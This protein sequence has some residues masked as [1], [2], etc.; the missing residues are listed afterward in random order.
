MNPFP[1]LVGTTRVKVGDVLQMNSLGLD[2]CGQ[3]DF[4]K[5]SLPFQNLSL[6]NGSKLTVG[7]W[8]VL[9]I[10]GGCHNITFLNS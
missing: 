8:K 2:I 6:K 5:L 7:T 10:T 9:S 3:I 4:Q 1:A